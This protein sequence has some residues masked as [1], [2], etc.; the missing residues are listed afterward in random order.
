VQ[1]CAL[2]IFAVNIDAVRVTVDFDREGHGFL[3]SAF[4][5]SGSRC[6]VT[7][8]ICHFDGLAAMTYIPEKLPTPGWIVVRSPKPR[9]IVFA[10]Y[11]GVSLLDLAGPLEAFRVASSFGGSR[12]S[13][14]TYECSV[15][16]IRGGPL[17][18]ADGVEL[19]TES[20]RSLGR[21][22]IDTL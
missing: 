10:V 17:K 12:E 13:R 9:R 7:Q 22:P 1:T 14:V 18:T 2:T 21:D 6:S 19:V 4:S 11:E 5:R 3:R 16:S 15:V 20:V 8:R